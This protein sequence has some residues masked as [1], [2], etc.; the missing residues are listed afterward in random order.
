MLNNLKYLI[1]H[2]KKKV[3]LN[4]KYNSGLLHASNL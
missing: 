4:L 2:I 3:N 1:L